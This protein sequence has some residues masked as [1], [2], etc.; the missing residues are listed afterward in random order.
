[1]RGSLNP[2]RQALTRRRVLGAAAAAVVVAARWNRHPSSEAQGPAAAWGGPR[3]RVI[4]EAAARA[5]GIRKLGGKHLTLYTDCEPARPIDELPDVFDQAV[6]QWCAYFGQDAARL[7]AWQARGFLMRRRDP[8]V[9]TGLLPPDLPPFP[10]GYSRGREFWLYEQPSDY[11]RRH[12]LLHEGTH[13]FSATV[14]R[15]SGPPWY[16]EGIA[17]LLATHRWHEDKLVLNWF[18]ASR[19]EVPMW[20]RIRIVQDAVGRGELKTVEEILGY[21][22]QAHRQVEPY[23][24]CWALA[25]FLDGHPRYQARFRQMVHHIRR[26]DFTDQFRRLFREDWGPMTEEWEVFAAELDYGT[27]PARVVI[28]LTVGRPLSDAGITVTVAADR[29]W[30]NSGIGLEAN[31]RYRLQ[32]SGRYQVA[33]WPRPWPC[34]PG[35]VS[36]RYHR[37][38]PLG[39]LLAAIRPA[40]VLR[41]RGGAGDQ[42]RSGLRDPIPVGLGITL[43]PARS[44]TL[45]FRINDSNGSLRDNAGS[46]QVRVEPVE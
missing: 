41:P 13:V 28:D 20:G 38:R 42:G 1:M 44:G 23:G 22:A 30:Q 4:S 14:L 16:M 36:I 45:F 19:M 17:E 9:R 37:G 3:L 40:S 39:Q 18:P 21:D 24:W 31:R 27:E 25:A 43:V 34:E 6:A 35:G 32:A 10:H 26:S 8:F 7:R 46:L 2:D 15:G 12:L 29:G 5:A 33:A 11:Y